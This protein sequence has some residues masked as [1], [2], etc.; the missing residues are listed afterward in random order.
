MSLL[1]GGPENLYMKEFLVH[2]TL[3]YSEDLLLF[4]LQLKQD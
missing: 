4:F 3:T 2:N 1:Q